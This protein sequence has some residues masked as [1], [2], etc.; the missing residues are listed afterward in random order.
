MGF[1]ENLLKKIRIDRLADNVIRSI[2]PTDSA[3][4]IDRDAMWQLLDM[5]SYDNQKERDLELYLLN[6]RHVLVL[7]NELKIYNSTVEDVGMRKSP[8]LKEMISIRNAIKI[9]ND[10]DVV[11]S[12]KADTVTRIR[13]ELT[14][15]LDLSYGVADIES[16]AQDGLEALKNKYAEGVV[17]ILDLFAELLGFDKANKTFR[18]SH[19]HIWGKSEISTSGEFHFGP[20]VIYGL[21]HNSLKMIQTPIN[22][23]NKQSVQRFHQVVRGKNDADLTNEGVFETLKQAVLDIPIAP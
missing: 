19:H 14:A 2:N 17:E 16:L 4:R 20:M 13:K 23:A 11:V 21:M 10:K 18:T 15:E 6:D 9:L 22:S 8:T 7:D 12:R 5:G 3:Q 1:R